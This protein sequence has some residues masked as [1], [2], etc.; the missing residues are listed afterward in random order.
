MFPDI[1]EFASDIRRAFD[2]L[3]RHLGSRPAGEYVPPV[4]VFDTPEGITVAVD[5]PGVP[6]EAMRALIKNGILIVIGDKPA[7]PCGSDH[8]QFHVAE[9]SFGRF[10][11]GVRLHGAYDAS[12][13]RATLY[14]GELRITVPRIEDRRGKEILIPIETTQSK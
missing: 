9:R 1:T 2:E 4:D 6:A 11:R 8:A 5:L 13:A 12:G 14:A 10:A 7:P 3:D